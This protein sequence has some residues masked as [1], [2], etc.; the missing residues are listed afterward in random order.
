[1]SRVRGDRDMA[2][3]HDPPMSH[4]SGPNADRVLVIGGLIVRGMGV[5]SYDLALSGHLARKLAAFTGRGADIETRGVD[6]FDSHHAEAVLRSEDLTRF[7]AVLIMLGIKEVM[8]LR[9]LRMWRVD[10]RQLLEV[11]HELAPAKMPSLM[12]GV[13]PFAMPMGVPKFV[14]R[15]VDRA[16][17]LMN[18][19][20]ERAC[21]AS[22]AAEYVPF[23]PELVGIRPG[24]NAGAIYSTW[25]TA[26]VPFLARALASQVPPTQPENE[27]DWSPGHEDARQLA[28]DDLG[29]VDGAPDARVGRIVEMARDML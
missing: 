25:A 8:S 26:L 20:T 21:A 19:E 3:P 11:L 27:S 23:H 4:G 29:V 6:G 17:D 13:A 24:A 7:D 1:M 12:V 9:P 2:F 15:W 10:I 18:A 14:V 22:G 5:A 16:A 28:L